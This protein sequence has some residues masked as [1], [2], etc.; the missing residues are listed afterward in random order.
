M[1]DALNER[2]HRTGDLAPAMQDIGGVLLLDK[3]DPTG[4]LLVV[5]DVESETGKGVVKIDYEVSE[6]GEDGI[7]RKT[8]IIRSGKRVPHEALRDETA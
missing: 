2:L 6:R 3:A 4:G 5:F 7:K 8:N 1:L